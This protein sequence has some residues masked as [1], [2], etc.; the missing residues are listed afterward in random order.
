MGLNIPV[1]EFVMRSDMACG[2][3]IGPITSGKIGIKTVDVGVPMLAMHSVRE[4][5]GADDAFYLYKALREYF[6]GSFFNNL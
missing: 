5:A 1:Q 2:S 3:T 4:M 6:K